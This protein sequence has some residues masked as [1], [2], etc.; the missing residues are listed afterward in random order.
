[1]FPQQAIITAS[2]MTLEALLNWSTYAE[3]TPPIL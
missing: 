1:M 3:M 2:G